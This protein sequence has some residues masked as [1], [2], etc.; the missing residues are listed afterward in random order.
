MRD[1]DTVLRDDVVEAFEVTREK[2]ESVGVHDGARDTMTVSAM[3]PACNEASSVAS[4]VRS[5]SACRRSLRWEPA[6][7]CMDGSGAEAFKV[8]MLCMAVPCLF[9][10]VL[11]CFASK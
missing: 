3:G 10:L 1:H 6:R 4:D 5:A 7:C 9:D 8:R 11:L 2:Q